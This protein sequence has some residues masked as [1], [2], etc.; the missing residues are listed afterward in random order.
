MAFTS[1]F[2]GHQS[3]GNGI[4]SPFLA[5][6]ALRGLLSN[7]AN[8]API[9]WVFI[10]PENDLHGRNFRRKLPLSAA[11]DFETLDKSARSVGDFVLS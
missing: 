6:I 1:A 9:N 4:S 7:S 5:G 10:I 3:P 11:F 2:A 8:P